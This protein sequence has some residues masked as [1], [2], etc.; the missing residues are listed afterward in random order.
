VSE[1][2]TTGKAPTCATDGNCVVA[3]IGT[4]AMFICFVLI[5]S[6][7]YIQEGMLYFDDGFLVILFI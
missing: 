6:C 1:C 5:N 7:I 4:A 2:G 3:G